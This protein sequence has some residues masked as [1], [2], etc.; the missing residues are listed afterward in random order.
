M[1]D[2]FIPFPH[3]DQWGLLPRLPWKIG[4]VTCNENPSY[5]SEFPS[6][7]NRMRISTKRVLLLN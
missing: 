3:V 2:K 7:E 6:H 1:G 5:I 4:V